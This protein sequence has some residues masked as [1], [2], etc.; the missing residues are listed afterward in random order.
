LEQNDYPWGDQPPRCN[1]GF[2]NGAQFLD[3]P[4]RDEPAHVKRFL[5]NGYG[6]YDMAGNVWEWVSDWYARDYYSQSEYSNPAGPE[7]G[8]IHVLRGGS[9]HMRE[10]SLRTAS[11]HQG[12]GI[13]FPGTPFLGVG[14]RCVSD[15]VP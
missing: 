4:C 6:L 3:S 5:P 9:W 12:A 11:R 13:N 1:S 7:S 10:D 15:E 14:F 8:V 2:V